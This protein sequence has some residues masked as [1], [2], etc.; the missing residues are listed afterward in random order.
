VSRRL[1]VTKMSMKTQDMIWAFA[2]GRPSN[3]SAAATFHIHS[4]YGSFAVDPSSSGGTPWTYNQKLIIGHA[5]LASIG[6]LVVLPLGALVA[7]WTRTF[8]PGAV[9]FT[10]HWFLNLAIGGPIIITGVALGYAALSNSGWFGT[11]HN[12]SS[13]SSPR[14]SS[15]NFDLQTI[16]TLLLVLYFVQVLF[17]LFI[18]FWKP[19][20]YRAPGHRPPYNYIHPVLG[21]AIVGLAFWQVRTGYSGQFFPYTG[22]HV[23]RAVNVV[24]IVWV[25]VSSFV[26][27]GEGSRR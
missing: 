2:S 22:H 21:I 11:M 25:V 23:P 27:M 3:S 24:W 19:R 10:S 17:G 7:R 4:G 6:F 1:T 12:V 16:G 9:W 5:V 8:V 15:T 13:S 26:G 14:G 18:H 20:R